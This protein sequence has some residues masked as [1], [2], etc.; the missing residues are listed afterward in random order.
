[1]GLSCCPIT[2]AT[3]VVLLT[4]AFADDGRDFITITQMDPDSE[5][6]IISQIDDSSPEN[7]AIISKSFSEAEKINVDE[8]VHVG[9]NASYLQIDVKHENNTITITSLHPLYEGKLHVIATADGSGLPTLGDR[10][11]EDV[12]KAQPQS[13]QEFRRIFDSIYSNTTTAAKNAAANKPSEKWLP[14]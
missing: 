10:K 3:F 7:K 14:G 9:R 4:S 11:M 12:I 1:M 6:R 2:I 8:R 13:Y 5:G